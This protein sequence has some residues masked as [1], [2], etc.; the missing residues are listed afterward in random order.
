MLHPDSTHR[1]ASAVGAMTAHVEATRFP[2]C[3][4]ETTELAMLHGRACQPIQSRIVTDRVVIRI[5]KDNLEVLV[6]GIFVD[7]VRVKHAKVAA[8]ATGTLLSDRS[9]VALELQL[10]NTLVLRL[11][12]LDSLLDRALA[13]TTTDTHYP[14]EFDERST[15]TLEWMT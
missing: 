11:T 15:Q 10:G 13:S 9:L 12:V 2:S 7:P 8:L 4:G 1:W 6:R 14:Q 5:D 3:G